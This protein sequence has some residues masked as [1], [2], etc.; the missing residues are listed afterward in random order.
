[1]KKTKILICDDLE[2][3]RESLKLILED[4]YELLFAKDGFEAIELINK[5]PI[6][7]ALLDI[8]MPKLNGIDALKKIRETKPEQKVLFVTGYQ[9]M[10]VAQ[11]A[12]QLGASD[13]IIKPFTSQELK[14][15]VNR[16]LAKK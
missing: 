4:D 2:S 14:S 13:Y 7:L 12:V 15:A 1:M 16:V 11:E 3:I 6:D 10:E 5:E 8:K 9:S